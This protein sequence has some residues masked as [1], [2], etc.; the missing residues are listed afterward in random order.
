MTLFHL[1]GLALKSDE[2][3][4][5]LEHHE[6]EVV[7]DFDRLHENT[8]DVYRALAPQAGFELRFND[9]QIL[10]TIFMYAQP[11]EPF[12]SIEPDMAGVPLHPGFAEAN[13]A[14]QRDGTPLRSSPNG[15]RWIK[16]DFGTHLIHYEFDHD[17]A[18]S[19][20]TVMTDD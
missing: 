9:Q 10:D 1:L 18:L 16:G 8:P 3:I 17:G 11:R 20:V 14:F 15:Q 2:V 13:A 4:E 12:S 5:L 6:V 19:L 7:Y